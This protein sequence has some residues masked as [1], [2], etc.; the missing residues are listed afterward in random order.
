MVKKLLSVALALAVVSQGAA[1]ADE[2]GTPGAVTTVPTRTALL[3]HLDGMAAGDTVAIATTEG[4][5]A[6][7][8]VDKDEDDV[9]IDRPLIEGGAERIAIPVAEIQGLRYQS[10]PAQAHVTAKAIVIT[11]VIVGTALLLMRALLRP[12]P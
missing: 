8:L 11:A 7:E 6:G 9:V 2:P 3:A 4:V 10:A 5:V 12:M 1:R